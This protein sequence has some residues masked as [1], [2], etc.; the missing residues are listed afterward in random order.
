[1][2]M[3]KR[4][5]RLIAAGIFLIIAAVV[6]LCLFGFV[7][8]GRSSVE[9]SPSYRSPDTGT[10]EQSVNTR[11]SGAVDKVNF[12]ADRKMFSSIWSVYQE[13]KKRSDSRQKEAAVELAYI[14]SVYKLA[15]I[16]VSRDL[17]K[18]YTYTPAYRQYVAMLHAYC[19]LYQEDLDKIAD[20]II[21]DDYSFEDEPVFR[22]LARMENV[23]LAG[24][25]E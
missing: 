15:S 7:S 5:A 3:S 10:A 4:K 19:T 1:M 6:A 16:R 22:L 14:R 17:D 25:T 9:F 18:L 20:G 12:A 13:D 23:W 21:K 11:M 8:R 24:M 2:T